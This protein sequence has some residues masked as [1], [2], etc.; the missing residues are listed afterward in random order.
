MVSDMAPEAESSATRLP[1]FSPRFFI[2]GK[3][4]GAI[5]ANNQNTPLLMNA[6]QFLAVMMG[7]ALAAVPALAGPHP[8][9]EALPMVGTADHGHAYPGAIV[10]FGMMQLS[11]DTPI[12]GWDGASGYHYSDTAIRGFSHTHL[13]G[14][15]VGCL[16]DVLV[17]RKGEH[18][19]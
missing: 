1:G 19:T 8:V 9:E 12:E 16:G 11:P 3:S 17:I 2:S 6:L 4:T 13:A 18:L 7:P 5:A 10:P 15:G 14:T